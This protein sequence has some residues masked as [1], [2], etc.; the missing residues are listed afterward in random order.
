MV[1]P[2]F[3]KKDRGEKKNGSEKSEVLFEKPRATAPREKGAASV[4]DVGVRDFETAVLRRS[5]EIPVLLDLWAPW[6]EPCRRLSPLL[7]RLANQYAGSFLLAKVDIEKH[8]E[9]A[10]LLRVQSV[11]T[12]I[13]FKDG[14]PVD[15]FMGA[16]SEGEI[17]RF[18]E[19]H[20]VLKKA[21]AEEEQPGGLLEQIG[22]GEI[23]RA[24]DL[25]NETTSP[26]DRLRVLILSGDTNKSRT[27][28]QE[29][30]GKEGAEGD[31][32]LE[33]AER[34]LGFFEEESPESLRIRESLRKNRLREL[35]PE[36]LEK[37]D[38]D[39]VRRRLLDL[40]VLMGRGELADE[41][42]TRL[43]RRVFS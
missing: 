15:A 4:I 8:A 26:P 41:I 31:P 27:L 28:L 11:P 13:L 21:S 36:L 18:L 22:R 24:R 25:V 14:R 23:A 38:D 33:S 43:A 42:R 7:E 35:L 20:I 40:L 19:R 1:I 5:L 30:K 10:M 17:R 37:A 39:S 3:G 16:L 2:L 6:C 29:L 9:I 12:V 34:L 32:V